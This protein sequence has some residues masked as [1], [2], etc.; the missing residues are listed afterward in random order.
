MVAPYIKE[1]ITSKS[2]SVIRKMFEEGVSLKKQYGDDAVFDFSLG[3]PDLDPPDAVV[4]AIAVVAADTS[5]GCH[6]YMQNAGYPEVRAAMA[7]KVSS[8]QGIAVPAETIVMTCGAASALNCVF[9][10]L[11]SPG[12]E[13]I[14]PSPFFA[15][16]RHY[17]HNYQGTLVE[18][19]SGADFSLDVQAIKKALTPQTAAVLINSPHNPTGKI[20]SDADIHALALVLEDH[21]NRCGRMPCLICDEPYRAITYDGK[22]VASVFPAYAASII[23]TSFA[24]NLSLP[25]ERIGYIAVNPACPDC[26]TVVAGCTFALRVLGF[27]NA[28]AFFQKVAARSWN[29]P[30]DYSSYETRRN[31]LMHILDDAGI[32]YYRPEG[33]F[34]LFCKVPASW[35][36]DDTAFCDHLKKY[37]I[38]SAPGNGFGRKGWFRLAYCVSE[39]TITNSAGAFK[40]AVCSGSAK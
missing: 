28:P 1:I 34:Y 18:V 25:G 29:A 12:D 39:K 20:Y 21:G 33:A 36:D 22:K 19:P 17:V 14:V 40:K 32:S 23:V 3:N 26:Q 13:V 37:F 16:Y 10:A 30:V 24:K 27:V 9:K 11:L 38:L 35:H 5:H 15:E 4:A 7:E 8:E 6:G 31:A 2:A